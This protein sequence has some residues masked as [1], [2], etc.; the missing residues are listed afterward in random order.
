MNVHSGAVHSWGVQTERGE[1]RVGD[2]SQV[3]AA[4]PGVDLDGTR[5]RG[6]R[7]SQVESQQMLRGSMLKDSAARRYVCVFATR[8][9]G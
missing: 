2:C 8:E 9:I 4:R 1:G 6:F 5:V 7:P 3:T